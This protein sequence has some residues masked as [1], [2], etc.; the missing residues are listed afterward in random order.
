MLENQMPTTL[1]KEILKA[2]PPHRGLPCLSTSNILDEEEEKEKGLTFHTITVS[3]GLPCLS[4]TNIVDEEEEK[5]KG[6]TFR[7]ITVSG[8]LLCPN[9]SNI[10]D[11]EEEREKWLTSKFLSFCKAHTVTLLILIF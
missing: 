8:G 5:L 2:I 3:G 4:P 11:E 6:L 9:L 7:T 10:V 1:L